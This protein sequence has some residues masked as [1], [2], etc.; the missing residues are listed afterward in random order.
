MRVGFLFRFRFR[1][2]FHFFLLLLSGLDV[3]VEE[4][5]GG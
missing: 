4:R 1:F 5:V 2:F 3:P